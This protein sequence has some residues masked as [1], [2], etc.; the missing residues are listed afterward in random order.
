MAAVKA[1]TFVERQQLRNTELV[2]LLEGERHLRAAMVRQLARELHTMLA[3]E[4]EL[5]FPVVANVAPAAH[6]TAKATADA[7]EAALLDVVTVPGELAFDAGL[8]RLRE[9]LMAH[10][11]ATRTLLDVADRAFDAEQ[12]QDLGIAMARFETDALATSERESGP[13]VSR[14]VVPPSPPDP[15]GSQERGAPPF[16]GDRHALVA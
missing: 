11:A 3:L 4:E 12:L 15:P 16:R 2:A 5:F 9:R 7:V 14:V 6:R 8:A 1:T 10:A 13:E